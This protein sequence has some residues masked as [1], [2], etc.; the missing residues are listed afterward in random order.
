MCGICAIIKRSHISKVEINN[1]LL[2]L[3]H[4]GFDSCGICMMDKES[5]FIYV[6]RQKNGCNFQDGDNLKS[7]SFCSYM[8][9]TR[10]TTQG[11][12]DDLSQIQPIV[13]A[14]SNIALGF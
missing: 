7:K 3:R 8:G 12:S 5:K 6:E 13:S 11:N 9:H 4:R 1:M 2:M 10:Y 14:D